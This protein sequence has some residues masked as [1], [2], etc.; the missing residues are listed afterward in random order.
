MNF[1]GE[2]IELAGPDEDDDDVEI[3]DEVLIWT[4]EE[5]VDEADEWEVCGKLLADRERWCW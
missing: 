5:T 4:D 2:M 1:V 3:G